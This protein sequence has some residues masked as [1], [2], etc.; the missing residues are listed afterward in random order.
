MTF[1]DCGRINPPPVEAPLCP[2]GTWKDA[3]SEYVWAPD[4]SLNRMPGGADANNDLARS[5]ALHAILAQPLDYVGAVAHDVSLAFHWTPARHPQRVT[6]AF[7]FKKGRWEPAGVPVWGRN[8]LTAYAP[9]TSGVYYSAE[10]YSGF[11]RGYQYPAYLRG[12]FL[13]AILLAGA[14]GLRRGTLVPWGAA[15]ALLVLPVAVLDFDHR[16]VLPV[17]PVACL[18]AAMTISGPARSGL[19]RITSLR[20]RWAGAPAGDVRPIAAPGD[21]AVAHS[22]RRLRCGLFQGH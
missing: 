12:P 4:S 1:A 22:S 6:P 19:A 18:A 11:L 13:A 16:Y 14:F 17:V 2:N 3:A 20:G 15:V 10:P 7:G 21:E 5:F 8:A 9:G